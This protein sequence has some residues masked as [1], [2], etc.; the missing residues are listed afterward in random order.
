MFP[1]RPHPRQRGLPQQPPDAQPGGQQPH[2]KHP[3]GAGLHR[4]AAIP[5]S[6]ASRIPQMLNFDWH[7]RARI[8][9]EDMWPACL[10]VQLGSRSHPWQR[11]HE[12]SGPV[13][14]LLIPRGERLPSE[15]LSFDHQS[16]SVHAVRDRVTLTICSSLY[17]S[18]DSCF[19]SQQLAEQQREADRCRPSWAP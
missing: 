7:T 9:F 1:V 6:G 4:R 19:F 17:L 12:T 14:T 11:P 10:G 15:G 18:S 3:P 5:V 2:R 13:Y 16:H 8:C